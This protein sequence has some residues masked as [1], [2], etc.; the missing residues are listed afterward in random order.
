M[1]TINDGGP[2]FPL[3]DHHGDGQPFLAETIR[4]TGRMRRSMRGLERT[5]DYSAGMPV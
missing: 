1:S 2:A 4:S 3:Y 5:L